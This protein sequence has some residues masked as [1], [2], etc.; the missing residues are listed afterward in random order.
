MFYCRCFFFFIIFTA[1]SPSFLCRSPWNFATWLEVCSVLS[2]RFQNLVGFPPK[3]SG[4]KTCKIRGGDFGQLQTSVANMSGTDRD[5]QY[6]KANV[7]TAIPLAFGEKCLVN[8]GPPTTKLDMWLCTHSPKATISEDHI[9]ASMG[10]CP[11]NFTRAREQ[12][13]LASAHPAGERVPQQFITMNIQ[14]LA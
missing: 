7:Y 4:A 8:F 10:C 2:S 13:R 3:K 14:K 12:P 11:S 5:I 9:L 6:R 1:R